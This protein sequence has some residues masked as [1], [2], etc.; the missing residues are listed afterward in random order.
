MSGRTAVLAAWAVAST[1]GIGTWLLCRRSASKKPNLV[2]GPG[3]GK[4]TSP[5]IPA[6]AHAPGAVITV[7]NGRAIVDQTVLAAAD[8]GEVWVFDPQNIAS[9]LDEQYGLTSAV[10]KEPS[11]YFDPL[12]MVH[13]VPEQMDS[14]SSA[15]LPKF[16]AADF[17]RSTDTL[18]LLTKDDRDS[19]AAMALVAMVLEEA[20]RYREECGGPSHERLNMFFDW[21]PGEDVPLWASI[22]AD[23]HL[24]SHPEARVSMSGA[25]EYKEDE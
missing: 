22:W 16:D 19:S 8:R 21:R 23:D 18:Y 11:L 24:A 14:A 20:E 1:I 13:Y 6:I 4:T 25:S 15:S 2:F 5:V 12:D 7:S 17:V 9:G 10:H 3:M